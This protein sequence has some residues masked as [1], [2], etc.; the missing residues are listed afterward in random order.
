MS[1]VVG[2]GG[3]SMSFKTTFKF[4][5]FRMHILLLSFTRFIQLHTTRSTHSTRSFMQ[6]LGMATDGLKQPLSV[7]AR[8]LWAKHKVFFE[9]AT[10]ADIRHDTKAAWQPT[11]Q[12][13]LEYKHT[14]GLMKTSTLTTPW[15]PADHVV[16]L[17]VRDD[18]ANTANVERTHESFC[19]CGGAWESCCDNPANYPPKVD[20][21]TQTNNAAVAAVSTI[22]PTVVAA[23]VTAHAAVDPVDAVEDTA[24]TA[25]SATTAT[26]SKSNDSATNTKHQAVAS[27]STST[28]TSASSV[29]AAVEI[30][31]AV[32]DTVADTIADI[33]KDSRKRRRNV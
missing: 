7:G 30:A 24:D 20:A 17:P 16:V 27:T 14:D 15:V 9:L 25:A 23:V 29:A 11:F 33:P 12:V 26:S 31:V 6:E 1:V 18:E 13:R 2:G 10:V 32:A 28:S 4:S 22:V 5:Q 8:V 21:T 3:Y 19:G